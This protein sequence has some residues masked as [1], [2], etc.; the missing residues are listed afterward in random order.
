RTDT[1]SFVLTAFLRLSSSQ[2]QLVAD[3]F[4]DKDDVVPPKSSRVNVRAAKST[5]KAPNKDH[6]KTV[7]HQFR[8][9]L[10]LLM[11]T[12][13]ATTPHYVRCIKPNDYKEAFS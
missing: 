12:L 1:R 2:F 3:L 7:G 11:E 13:N 5:P 10:Q 8:S 9:S 6:R 4:H